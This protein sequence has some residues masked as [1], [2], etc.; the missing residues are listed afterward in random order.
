VTAAMACAFAPAV[1]SLGAVAY[2]QAAETATVTIVKDAQPNG[3]RNFHFTTDIRHNNEE[4]LDN[5]T[6]DDDPT[7]DRPN[8]EQFDGVLPGTYWVS[9]QQEEGWTLGDINCTGGQVS[10]DLATRKVTITVGAGDAVNCTFVNVRNAQSTE[11]TPEPSPSPTPTVTLAAQPLQEGTQ[12]QPEVS[13]D[14]LAAAQPAAPSASTSLP[15]QLPRTG[16]GIEMLA[17]FGAALIAAGTV[18]L[19]RSRRRTAADRV[20]S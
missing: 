14:V 9:E 11:P 1:S 3:P 5:F 19:A 16:S 2:S 6:L 13:G 18:L 20:N 4:E 7:S 8:T 17:G 15:A 12:A 10:K